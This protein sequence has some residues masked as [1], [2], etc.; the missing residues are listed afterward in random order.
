MCILLSNDVENSEGESIE[1]CDEAVYHLA[2]E[3]QL[4]CPNE[5]T[6]IILCLESFHGQCCLNSCLGKYLRSSGAD[7]I[8]TESGYLDVNVVESSVVISRPTK[9]SRD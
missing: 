6:N 1:R 9:R 3:I 4:I 2:R 7:S 8:L 5:F